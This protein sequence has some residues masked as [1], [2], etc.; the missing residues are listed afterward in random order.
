MHAYAARRYGSTSPTLAA[1]MDVL[2]PAAYTRDIDTSS[3]EKLP[4]VNE[5]AEP[6]DS[7]NT[8]ATG[9]LAALR[10]FVQAAAAGEVDTTTGPWSYD[11]TDLSRQV[12]CNLF[13]DA[14]TLLGI[15][16]TAAQAQGVNNTA[17]VAALRRFMLGIIADLD[18]VNSADPNYLLGTWLADAAQWSAGSPARLSNLLFNAKNQSA[19][20]GMAGWG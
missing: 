4:E 13:S 9:I 7:R 20:G 15:R 10:L 1:A 12:L 6:G 2:L 17:E 3:V 14:H 19:W 16:W 5:N 18:A 11:L 8:N